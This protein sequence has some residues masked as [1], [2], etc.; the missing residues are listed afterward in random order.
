MKQQIVRSRLSATERESLFLISADEDDVV[1]L[2]TTI[3]KDYNL[4]KKRGWKLI[5]EYVYEDGTVAGG[6]FTA[7]RRA[8][9]MR[10]VQAK[11]LSEKQKQNLLKASKANGE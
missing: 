9:S 2:D 5:E 1:L 10:G 6:K 11:Q 4:A 8:L 7:P 3:L